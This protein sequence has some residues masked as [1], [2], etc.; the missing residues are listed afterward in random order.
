MKKKRGT[1]NSLG[2][3]NS[4]TGEYNRA[5]HKKNRLV[6]GTHIKRKTKGLLPT[7]SSWPEWKACHGRVGR[8]QT[9]RS[10]L[11]EKKKKMPQGRGKVL[12]S[13]RGRGGA[14]LGTPPEGGPKPETTAKRKHS[15]EYV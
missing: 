14:L 7:S 6:G 8:G 10:T 12:V 1:E 9:R 15:G 11:R 3:W 13:S 4:V 5:G 2:G